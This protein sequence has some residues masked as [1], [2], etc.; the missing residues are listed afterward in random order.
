MQYA[1]DSTVYEGKGQAGDTPAEAPGRDGKLRGAH[2]VLSV[3]L[4]LTEL[5]T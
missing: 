4:E 1:E 2:K 3:C 5:E